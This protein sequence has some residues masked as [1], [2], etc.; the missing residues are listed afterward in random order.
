MLD[1]YFVF[2]WP[3]EDAVS[4]NVFDNILN[5][6]KRQTLFDAKMALIPHVLIS[7]THALIFI[8]MVEFLIV[9]KVKI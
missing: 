9:Y 4:Y 7:R 2:L 3:F 1:E 5:K 8:R 6:N